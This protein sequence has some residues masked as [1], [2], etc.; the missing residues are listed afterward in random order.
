MRR[1]RL[2]R[3]QRELTGRQLAELADLQPSKISAL[4]LGRYTPAP[5]SVELKR[6]AMALGFNSDQADNLLDEV[7]VDGR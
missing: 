4:E 3:L 2:L 6:V 1:L 7:S 5:H